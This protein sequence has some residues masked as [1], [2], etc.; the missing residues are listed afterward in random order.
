[1]KIKVSTAT[2]IHRLLVSICTVYWLTDENLDTFHSKCNSCRKKGGKKIACG[3]PRSRILR[4]N[5]ICPPSTTVAQIFQ[6]GNIVPISVNLPI[7]WK[8]NGP[9]S[10]HD[11]NQELNL[12][13]DPFLIQLKKDSGTSEDPIE[14][15]FILKLI[16]PN[17]AISD[18]PAGP[19]TGD[20]SK[21]RPG[22]CTGRR[23][24]IL[25]GLFREVK[26]QFDLTMGKD[27]IPT[28]GALQAIDAENISRSRGPYFST[29]MHPTP[30]V[31]HQ[32]IMLDWKP[33][34]IRRVK[35]DRTPTQQDRKT[36][37][38]TEMIVLHNTGGTKKTAVEPPDPDQWINLFPNA[39][40]TIGDMLKP[41]KAKGIHYVVDVDG[42]V[43]KMAHENSWTQHGGGGTTPGWS[44]LKDWSKVKSKKF[45]PGIN[46]LAVGIEHSLLGTDPEF[47]PE[48]INASVNLVKEL[49]AHLPGYRPWNL[50]GHSQLS[51]SRQVCP[52]TNFP[53]YRYEKL[54]YDILKPSLVGRISVPTMI[55]VPVALHADETHNPN[56]ST[57][58]NGFFHSHP[59]S[60]LG[61]KKDD[62]K[63]IH[64]LQQDLFEIGFIFHK[65]D[66]KAKT[67][68]IFDPET[69]RSVQQFHK[70]FMNGSHDTPQDV[71]KKQISIVNKESA[72]QIKRILH[73]LKTLQKYF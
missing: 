33:D 47:Y 5:N 12:S 15:T 72:I 7:K 45:H 3:L 14:G 28:V 16:P 26:L 38:P 6:D 34:W 58:Y 23:D 51:T 21:F 69:K 37:F 22:N 49:A 67:T 8:G 70:R 43:T 62:S 35:P 71:L 20:D 50:I 4:T 18:R 27:G 32:H 25:D 9:F 68:G 30:T 53:W 61:S 64:E 66:I 2:P 39:G 10:F 1:M 56:L 57:I 36:K 65:V 17:N 19:T 29:M 48:L 63:A 44:H 59:T 41:N 52:G 11:V 24:D 55:P 73:K 60:V 54:T 40:L 42:H 31:A 46:K 13:L